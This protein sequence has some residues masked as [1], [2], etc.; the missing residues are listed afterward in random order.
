M[1]RTPDRPVYRLLLRPEPGLVPE[2]VRLRRCLK[3]LLR[4]FGLRC[5]DF[6]VEPGPAAVR[7][8]RSPADGSGGTDDR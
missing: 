8:G 2:H 3:A 5:I 6:D 1:T 4:S 7:Q